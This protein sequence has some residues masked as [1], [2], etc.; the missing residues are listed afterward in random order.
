M[1][2]VTNGFSSD[3]Q[4]N[5]QQHDVDK[6]G[7]LAGERQLWCSFCS[8]HIPHCILYVCLLINLLNKAEWWKLKKDNDSIKEKRRKNIQNHNGGE[9]RNLQDKHENG[10]FVSQILLLYLVC[11][12]QQ[13]SSGVDWC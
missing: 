6:P 10:V 7:A 12:N 5:R 8:V 2:W 3:E 4:A 9:E 1:S 13:V 11:R